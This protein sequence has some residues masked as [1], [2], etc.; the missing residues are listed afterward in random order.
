[1]KELTNSLKAVLYSRVSSPIYSTFIL[2]WCVYNWEAVLT[3]LFSEEALKIR[4]EACKALFYTDGSFHWGTFWWPVGVTVFFLVVKPVLTSV[5]YAYSEWLKAKAEKKKEEFNAARLLT[6]EQSQSYIDELNRYRDRYNNLLVERN[7]EFDNLS[8]QKKSLQEQL[9]S[10]KADA[11][12][13]EAAQSDSEKTLSGLKN[14][15]KK[16]RYDNQRLQSVEIDYEDIKQKLDGL[17]ERASHLASNNKGMEQEIEKYKLDIKEKEK[18]MS[19]LISGINKE[20]EKFHNVKKYAEG[21]KN[22]LDRN[23]I[24][25]EAVRDMQTAMLSG[26]LS[27]VQDR[28]TFLSKQSRNDEELGLVFDMVALS[29]GL[30]RNISEAGFY[31]GKII[32]PNINEFDH[33]SHAFIVES[34]KSNKQ[35]SGLARYKSLLNKIIHRSSKIAEAKDAKTYTKVVNEINDKFSKLPGIKG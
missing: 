8:N 24:Y 21:L 10:V 30:P 1:M 9:E 34:V 14:E 18:K 16:L 35:Y 17:K 3:L 26:D 22:N 2:A 29:S 6:L 19:A 32:I 12:T 33:K 13:L 4:I 15:N 20:S 11:V 27:W 23:S 5:H 28:F 25:I 31:L 7:D